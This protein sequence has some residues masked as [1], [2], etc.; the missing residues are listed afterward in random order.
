MNKPLA[1]HPNSSATER[2]PA[3]TDPVGSARWLAKRARARG[4]SLDEDTSFPDDDLIEV[5]NTGLLAAPLP[6]DLGGLGW[7]DGSG[8]NR[9]LA[10]VLITLGAASLPLGRLYEGHVNAVKLVTAH[11]TPAQLEQVARLIHRGELLAVWNTQAKDGVRLIGTGRSRRLEGRKTFCSGAG[12]VRHPL[13]TARD[14]DG[15]LLMIIPEGVDGTR[16]DLSDWTPHGMR[17]SAS[18]AVDFSG[19]PVED[20]QI[21]GGDD[22]FHRQPLFSA[23]AWRFVAVQTGG[24]AAVLDAARAHLV[25]N[26]RQ[27]APHQRARIGAA[28]IA[29]Q[30][31]RQW[32]LEAARMADDT[33]IDPRTRISY[34]NLARTAVERAGLDVLELAQRSVGL[35]GFHRAHPLE[36]LARDLATY[37]RQPDP[38]G[39]LDDAG[40]FILASPLSVTDIFPWP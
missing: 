30:S 11:G 14:E 10:Q 40:A 29:F 18:G 37:L 3:L 32:V 34:V 12:H 31:A 24:I 22:D 13:V 33:T 7:S 15:H 35:A 1:S 17:A 19:L 20:D 16:T 39:A 28:A 6:F 5:S 2:T 9:D 26:G 4:P 38:D 8:A 25:A 21:I 36:K 27:D 23:G